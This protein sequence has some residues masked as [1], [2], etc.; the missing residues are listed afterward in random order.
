MIDEQES[1]M[2]QLF[3]KRLDMEDMNL[4]KRQ[5]MIDNDQFSLDQLRIGT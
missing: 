1:I 3:D 4:L 5:E 2:Q